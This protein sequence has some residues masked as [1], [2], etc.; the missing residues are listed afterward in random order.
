M[1]SYPPS[2]LKIKGENGKELSGYIYLNASGP[3][4]HDFL[5][6][7]EL[8]VS[9]QIKDKTGHFSQPVSFKVLLLSGKTPKSPSEGVFKEA[10][11]GP[12]MVTLRPSSGQRL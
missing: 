10:E 12:I 7:Q 11:L 6:N 4:G 3:A 1:G 5:H 8:T 9:V 2:F